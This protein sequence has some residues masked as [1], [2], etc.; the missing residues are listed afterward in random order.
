MTVGGCSRCVRTLVNK[1]IQ[2]Y[3]IIQAFW[4][5]CV[6]TYIPR[7]A[8]MTVTLSEVVLLFVG[9]LF[10]PKLPG[11]PLPVPKTSISF[12][13]ALP[14]CVNESLPVTKN[15]LL[16][17]LSLPFFPSVCNKAMWTQ[18]TGGFLCVCVFRG[19][20]VSLLP[21]LFLAC[22][23]S[24]QLLGLYEGRDRKERE[25]ER[26]GRESPPPSQPPTPSL[27]LTTEHCSCSA[28]VST[29]PQSEWIPEGSEVTCGLLWTIEREEEV[30]GFED[31]LWALCQ[32][33]CVH[34]HH[35]PTTNAK[36]KAC[37]HTDSVSCHVSNLSTS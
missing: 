31:F 24:A 2:S 17:S 18:L 28:T 37:R 10:T 20:I 5:M 25:E 11:S 27:L 22:C 15:L 30:V 33:M 29:F 7:D 9:F 26:R 23:D 13:Y 12:Y 8:V 14:H 4:H 6:C 32:G 35:L 16:L 1:T 36:E 19:W 3:T 21:C 34:S